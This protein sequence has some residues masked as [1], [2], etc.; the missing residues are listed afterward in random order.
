MKAIN[1]LKQLQEQIDKHGEDIEVFGIM[2]G[3]ELIGNS[4][5]CFSG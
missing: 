5:V 3:I 2:Y 4:P 1:L